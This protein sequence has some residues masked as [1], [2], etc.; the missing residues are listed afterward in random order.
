EKGE[1]VWHLP[2]QPEGDFSGFY[3][4]FLRHRSEGHRSE[5]VCAATVRVFGTRTA[6]LPL[7]GTRF[8][9]RCRGLCR[10]LVR[11]VE[12]LLLELGVKLLVLPAVP[13]IQPTWTRAFGFHECTP[14]ERR[15]LCELGILLFPGTILLQKPISPEAFTPSQPLPRPAPAPKVASSGATRAQLRAPSTTHR[16]KGKGKEGG[17]ASGAGV[18]GRA[19][20]DGVRA[21]RNKGFVDAEVYE[22]VIVC[23]TR[24]QRSVRTSASVLEA[25]K[26]LQPRTQGNGR[27]QPES[28]ARS[29]PGEKDTPE[30]VALGETPLEGDASSPLHA[31][32]PK[33]RRS[34]SR[35]RPNSIPRTGGG[36]IGA[37]W[38]ERPTTARLLE[39]EST[40]S[41]CA[42]L[43]AAEAEEDCTVPDDLTP[44][45]VK[46][47]QATAKAARK[48][49]LSADATAAR[50]ALA[51]T[52]ALDR[53]RDAFAKWRHLE[54]QEAERG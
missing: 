13:A 9:W 47:L 54:A 20:G 1:V 19:G 30:A 42:R 35:C 27:L 52:E 33:G 7:I 44:E 29:T 14:T 4:I 2:S 28:G 18:K 32:R 16:V 3:T 6:E 24:S 50:K 48:A 5:L 40:E 34:K 8:S 21:E 11:V 38:G 15:A 12:E 36:G 10:R 51:A 41:L 25:I 31:S 22:Q 43:E 45:N 49:M 17:E 23:T 46:K 53:A 26:A 39:S 37:S